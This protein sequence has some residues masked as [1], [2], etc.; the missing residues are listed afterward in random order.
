[1]TAQPPQPRPDPVAAALQLRASDADRERVAGLLRDAFAEGR[2]SPVEHEER[3]A[4]VYR[5]ATYGELVPVLHDLPVPPGTLAVPGATG[6][7]VVSVSGLPAGSTGAPGTV[8]LAP[9]QA[10]NGETSMAAIFGGVERK[11]RWIVAPKLN[12]T[13]VF[14]SGL[15]DLTN[16]VLTSQETEINANCVF[17]GI[18]M[19]VPDGVAVQIETTAIF[20]GAD[21]PRGEAPLPGAPVLRITGAVVFGGITVKRPGQQQ[22]R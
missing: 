2:L 10:R 20:G 18:E 9:E 17:G 7:D 6:G 12:L 1:M 5:A 11:G 3:L 4:D 21:A 15:L 19:T 22:P 14:G 13:C 16:V 8:V